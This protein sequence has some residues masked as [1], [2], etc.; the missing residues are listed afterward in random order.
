MKKFL[1]IIALLALLTVACN[2]TQ[3]TEDQTNIDSTTMVTDSI[4]P[5]IDTL[6]VK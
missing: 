5:V 3:P 6:V 1:S 2:S 4:S